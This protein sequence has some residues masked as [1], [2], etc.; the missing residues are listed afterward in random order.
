ML[1]VHAH[2]EEL[3]VAGCM[4]VVLAFTGALPSLCRAL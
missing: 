4:R 2:H 1:E 3:E